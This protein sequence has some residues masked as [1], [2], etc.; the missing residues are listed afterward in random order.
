MQGISGGLS[1]VLIK[2]LLLLPSS[3]RR[4]WYSPRRKS[5]ATAP[6]VVHVFCSS[7]LQKGGCLVLTW[8]WKTSCN[9]RLAFTLSPLRRASLTCSDVLCDET[10]APASLI[11]GVFQHYG[12]FSPFD[13]GN[14]SSGRGSHVTFKAIVLAVIPTRHLTSHFIT[15][16]G[17]D[18]F[19]SGKERTVPWERAGSLCGLGSCFCRCLRLD[20]SEERKNLPRSQLQSTLP[21]WEIVF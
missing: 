13:W 10:T 19:V 21:G 9:L 16:I 3:E 18:V 5:K 14:M 2:F 12:V 20:A 17:F 7:V 4:H 11:K 8:S 15:Q 6:G 1:W